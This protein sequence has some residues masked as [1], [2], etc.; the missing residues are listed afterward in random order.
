MADTTLLYDEDC[1]FCRWALSHV[2]AWDRNGRLRAIALQSPEAEALV[3]AMSRDRRMASWHL[4]GAD[5]RTW[6][7]G[8]AVAPLLR[9][10]PFGTPLAAAAEAVPGV[11]DWSYAWVAGHRTALGRVL[12]SRAC[13]VPESRS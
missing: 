4:V 5:G 11:I 12:G 2:L 8:D 1:G 6:S 13:V 3:P 9:R 10:L 7:A